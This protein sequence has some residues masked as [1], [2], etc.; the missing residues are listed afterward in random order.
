MYPDWTKLGNIEHDERVKRNIGTNGNGE[1]QPGWLVKPVVQS[2]RALQNK[3]VAL[4]AQMKHYS[5]QSETPNSEPRAT[6]EHRQ[7]SE[8]I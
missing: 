3:A 1:T 2:V 5:A 8:L 6:G 7:A 4:S